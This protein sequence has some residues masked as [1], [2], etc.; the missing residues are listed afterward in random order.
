MTIAGHTEGDLA[1]VV[2]DESGPGGLTTVS[3]VDNTARRRTRYHAVKRSMDLAGAGMGL[4]VLSPVFLLL[5]VLIKLEDARGP[6][7]FHQT[8]VGKDEKEFRMYKF[9]SMIADAENQLDHLLG[10]NEIKGAM[11][12]MKEDP[13]ITRI[14]RVIRKTSL[15]ELPQLLNVLRGE[16]SLV[17]PRPPLPRE[18]ATYTEYDKQ[19]LAVTPGCTGLWQVSGRNGLTF[20]QMVELDLS[21]I[22][23]RSIWLDCWIVLRTVAVLFGSKNAY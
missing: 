18:V 16:M 3:T 4:L 15:D 9:R 7:F 6:V 20:D 11:F 5:A 17:G 19:R 14:G 2:T 22:K 21:Y 8:R 23:R 10:E 1:A 13:R 12:K